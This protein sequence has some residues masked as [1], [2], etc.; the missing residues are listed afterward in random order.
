M[1]QP[2]RGGDGGFA[3]DSNR[4]WMEAV[5]TD[6]DPAVPEVLRIAY[7][8]T[9][10]AM[11]S[12]THDTDH[13]SLPWSVAIIPIVLQAGANLDRCSTPIP[14]DVALRVWRITDVNSEL[15]S[16]WW[17]IFQDNDASLPVA[18][19]DLAV[20]LSDHSLPTET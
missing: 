9:R 20:Q 18:L 11:E 17:Q 12:F 2:M 5:L 8:L 14:I 4:I 10:L 1:V 13:E 19:Q 6:I 15:L 16:Q 3:A 7:L